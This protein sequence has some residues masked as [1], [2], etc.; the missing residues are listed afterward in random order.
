MRNKPE[1]LIQTACKHRLDYWQSQGVVIDHLDISELGKKAFRGHWI[2]RNKK[3]RNDL[4]AYVK[5][6]DTLWLYLMEIKSKTATQSKE[7]EEY[8]EK[9]KGVN[10]VV[11]QVV[12]HPNEVDKTI[13]GLTGFSQEKLDSFKM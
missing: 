4:L 8:Q 13:D 9:F 1:L 5:V 10:N 7:Q 11:Y 2:M 12:R 3:G 6:K